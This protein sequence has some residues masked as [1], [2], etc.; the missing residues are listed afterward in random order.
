MNP[1]L[2]GKVGIDFNIY[3]AAIFD[4]DLELLMESVQ[5]ARKAKKYSSLPRY[6]EVVLAFAVVVDEEVSVREVREY[7]MSRKMDRK[8][9]SSSLIGKVELF[10]IYR[11]KPLHQGKK[12]LAF[13]VYYRRDDRTLTEKEANV[14]HEDIAERIRKHGWELR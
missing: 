10:D 12:N 1:R 8:G 3:R 7:I 11:G 13:N 5:R 2:L 14:V 9:T 4:I 6:P